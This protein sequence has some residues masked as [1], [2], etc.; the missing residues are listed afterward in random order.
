MINFS[1]VQ[2][3]GSQYLVYDLVADPHK[4]DND[5]IMMINS[6]QDSSLGLAKISFEDINGEK[7]K[8]LFDITGMMSLGE[9]LNRRMSQEAFRQLI[10]QLA[11]TIDNFDN[12]MI[13]VRQVYLNVDY[14]YVNYIEK[15]IIFLCMPFSSEECPGNT[16]VYEFFR[17]VCNMSF[18]NVEYDGHTSYQNIVANA[19]NSKT[20]FSISNL[21]SVLSADESQNSVTKTAPSETMKLNVQP[22][23]QKPAGTVGDVAFTGPVPNAVHPKT[24]P[25][26]P[27]IEM[28]KADSKSSGSLFGKMKDILRKPAD[29]KKEKA[30]KKEKSSGFSGG[31]AGLSG[32]VKKPA[33]D[34]V[35]PVPGIQVNMPVQTTQTTASQPVTPQMQMSAADDNCH[36]IY[37]T[38][39]EPAASETVNPDSD[40]RM[41]DAMMNLFD[42]PL[43]GLGNGTAQNSTVQQNLGGTNILSGGMFGAESVQQ[44]PSAPAV[45]EQNTPV[46]VAAADDDCKTVMMSRA[47]IVY[48]KTGVETKL[49]TP[50]VR[51]GRSSRDDVEIRLADS[52]HVGRHHAEFRRKGTDYVLVDLNSANHT[53]LN[54]VTLEPQKEYKINSGDQI[55]FADEKFEYRIEY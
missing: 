37:V 18:S 48:L 52:I 43:S 53:L 40:R 12:Y 47:S 13:D 32:L 15:R 44:T 38:D 6:N 55:V 2:K 34:Q 27:M 50:V 1:T 46:S 10:L 23:I 49:E 25:G 20:A 28:P 29:E 21:R 24:T 4:I 30:P 36:T 19:L 17:A 42:E 14:V 31:I 22:E 7:Q 39:H 35:P 41:N 3:G 26:V 45:P 11:E 51:V 9:F 5:T 54:G 16:G 33:A 8:M